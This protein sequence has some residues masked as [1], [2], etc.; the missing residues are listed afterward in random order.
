LGTRDDILNKIK[1]KSKKF[2]ELREESRGQF[3]PE[4]AIAK[5]I[6]YTERAKLEVKNG[7]EYASRMESA[8]GTLTHQL[9]KIDGGVLINVKW[10]REDECEEWKDL[11]VTGVQ[12]LWSEKWLKENPGVEGELNYGI[13]DM[14][15]EG[16]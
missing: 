6:D 4:R 15:L 7:V 12:V 3:R 11:R 2:S 16:I 14:F 5:F 8:L 13:D 9:R 10:Y 1:T